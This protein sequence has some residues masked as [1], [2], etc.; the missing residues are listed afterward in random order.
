MEG[1]SSQVLRVS[2]AD[3]ENLVNYEPCQKKAKL[4]DPS[5][6]YTNRLED[7]LN[8]ILCCAV[9]LDLP[10][11]CYQVGHGSSG[12]VQFDLSLCTQQNSPLCVCVYLIVFSLPPFSF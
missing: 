3:K 12:L 10:H 6:D 11:T 7:R 2:C 8:G 1:E 9:C 4:S 5:C